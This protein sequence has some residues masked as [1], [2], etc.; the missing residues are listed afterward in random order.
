MKHPI[1]QITALF[2]CLALWVLLVPALTSEVSA[3][4]DVPENFWAKED[5]RRSVEQGYFYPEADGR[6]GVGTEMTRADF[7]VVLC[8]F[9][10]WK[11]T[12]PARVI[13]EDVP[14]SAWY[15]G[16]VEIAYR[17]GAI[18]DQNG[19]FRPDDLI[20]RS[21][22]ASML[23]RALG[24]GTI[25]GLVQDF[26]LPFQDV[27]AN[28]GYISMVYGL[29]LMD[30]ASVTTFSPNDTITREQ[31]ADILMRLYDKLH[32]DKASR[33]GLISS[34]RN[35]PDLRDYESVSIS[36][37][38]L[39]YNGSPQISPS[40]EEEELET[41][42]TAARTAGARQLLHV[43]G[44]SY[45]LRE[46]GAEDM[47]AVLLEAVR[48]GKYDG[49]TLEISGLTT[50]PQRKE[51]TA[52][53]ETLRRDLGSSLLLY[54]IVEAPAWKGTVSGYDYAA[55]GE[56]ADRVI[57]RIQSLSET[58]NGVPAAPPEP[59]E[60]VYYGLSRMRG[61][62]DAGKLTLMV[63]TAGSA[64][65]DST[66]TDPMTGLEIAAMLED[67]DTRVY[68]SDRYASAYAQLDNS[69]SV[70]TVWYLNGQSIEERVRLGRLF[71]INQLCLS[72]LSEALP[73]T[74]EAMP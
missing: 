46:G 33:T 21:E 12:L 59:L 69:R 34:A 11:P 1:Q 67:P 42:R 49:L 24:Y 48:S 56:A 65:T 23:V 64:W 8:R 15:A 72:E 39:V 36:A 6:F 22:A 54:I 29:G 44:G 40:L 16:A 31:A 37:A 10:G 18:T 71:G 62:V 28:S 52:V 50:T 17:Q 32:A 57:L 30:G 3:L 38:H 9:F 26:P 47:A 70:T 19:G 45:Q 63:S 43:T 73:E 61:L 60:E 7:V 25:A 4:S 35:L 53:V 14:S 27:R 2:T 51:L 20:T 55:L 68:Y 13:Y 5:I 74:L 66:P 58:I 41:I